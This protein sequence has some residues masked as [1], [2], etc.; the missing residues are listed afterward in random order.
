M[1]VK[2]QGCVHYILYFSKLDMQV[3]FPENFRTIII[4][5]H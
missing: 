1:T 5:L 2:I 4:D 3:T